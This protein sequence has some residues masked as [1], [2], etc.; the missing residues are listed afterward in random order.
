M[1]I[2]TYYS[3]TT[4]HTMA[5]AQ[6]SNTA[7]GGTLGVT[8][9]TTL[10]STLAVSGVSNLYCECRLSIKTQIQEPWMVARLFMQPMPSRLSPTL[11][12]PLSLMNPRH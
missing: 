1:F 3:Q 12:L 9:A 4:T 7:V 8:G 11:S 6:L 10:S 5:H 2:S